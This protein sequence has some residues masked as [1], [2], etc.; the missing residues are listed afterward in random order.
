MY[1]YLVKAESTSETEHLLNNKIAQLPARAVFTKRKDFHC[2]LIFATTWKKE[3]TIIPS[4]DEKY[5]YNVIDVKL[6]NSAI[7]LILDADENSFVVKRHYELKNEMEATTDQEIY[8]PHMTLGHKIRGRFFDLDTI[9]REFIGISV[10]LDGENGRI[11][12]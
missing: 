1:P 8:T 7:V 5:T 10:S 2:T 3:P 6:F 9:K 4:Y 11:F 12:R